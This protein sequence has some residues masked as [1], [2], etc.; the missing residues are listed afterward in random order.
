MSEKTANH[1]NEWTE[2]CLLVALLILRDEMLVWQM[3]VHKLIVE[4][5]LSQTKPGVIPESTTEER[6]VNVTSCYMLRIPLVPLHKAARCS[7]I[8]H[9]SSVWFEWRLIADLYSDYYVGTVTAPIYESSS[10]YP[11]PTQ[12]RGFWHPP[13][14]P[15]EFWHPPHTQPRELWHP[16]HTQP[17]ELWQP[18]PPHTHTTQRI[19]VPPHTTQRIMTPH[20]HTT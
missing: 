16:T 10:H 9:I 20:A 17:R 3:M 6:H 15:R 11:S 19:Q 4:N 18:P 12:P 2:S 7:S 1:C 13:T 5:H 14:Q 8:T